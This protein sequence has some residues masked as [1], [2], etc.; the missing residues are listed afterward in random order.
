MVIQHQVLP[1]QKFLKTVLC[2]SLLDKPENIQFAASEIE[3]CRGEVINFTCSAD[4]NPAVHTYQLLENDVLLTDGSN[5]HGMWNRT[6]SAGGAFIYKC[7]A[8][9]TAGIGQSE[10]VTVT[11]NGKFNK[12]TSVFHASVLLL[13]INFVFTLSK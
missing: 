12:L 5:N 13:I 9:N 4:G 1:G 2:P 8:N 10:S 7:L 3:V 11:I 6:M